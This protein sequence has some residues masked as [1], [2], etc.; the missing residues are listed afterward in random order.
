MLL[1]LYQSLI[2]HRKKIMTATMHET[3]TTIA[4]T[5]ETFVTATAAD[6]LAALALID[7]LVK[8]PA[9]PVLG[10]VVIEVKPDG[11]VELAATN[12]SSTVT[13]PLGNLLGSGGAARWL[14]RARELADTIK[15]VAM[16]HKSAVIRVT[17]VEYADR[18]LTL[19]EGNGFVIP[20]DNLP[21]AE[22]PP[23]PKLS[24]PTA[25]RLSTDVFRDAVE[26]T[27]VASSQD[28]TLPVL[29][30]V[31]FTAEGDE[32]RLQSTDRYRLV[33]SKAPAQVRTPV[34]F[35]LP[36]MLLRQYTRYMTGKAV[37]IIV[38]ESSVKFIFERFTL[39]AQAVDGDYPKLAP[40]IADA[41]PNTVRLNRVEFARAARVARSL[42][43]RSWGQVRVSV[44]RT[45]VS[46]TP[47]LEGTD[48]FTR[49]LMKA[50][51][52]PAL[53]TGDEVIGDYAFNPVY[54]LD[55]I[56]VLEADTIT[57]SFGN[58]NKP[59]VFT[60]GATV[61]DAGAD[62]H[63]RYLLMPVRMGS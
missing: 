49:S 32:L 63:M 1:H 46:V 34:S 60:N 4:P 5:S 11:F 29:C 61:A 43:P 10:G 62:T 56:K 45:G 19:V 22:Y 3:K 48:E 59:F 20:I 57:M 25:V 39:I 42:S 21:V 36:M 13:T 12:Y 24:R 9:V 55:A 15:T 51:F 50:P 14:V 33:F 16:K 58:P 27:I 30:S 41:Y 35:I 6:W 40:L 7:P 8:R 38:D 47:T 44:S 53:T 28:D 18:D 37:S 2:S 31:N 23:L 54:L 26:R 52:I 17:R